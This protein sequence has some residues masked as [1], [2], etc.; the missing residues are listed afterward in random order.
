MP[1]LAAARA[2]GLS[3]LVGNTPLLG[4]RLRFRGTERTIFASSENLAL[5]ILLQAG[6]RG[7]LKPGGRIIEATSGNTGISFAALG[8]A[9][10]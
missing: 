9:L 4:I 6:R 7:A 3:T 2:R 10:R 8:R 5:H 1:Q